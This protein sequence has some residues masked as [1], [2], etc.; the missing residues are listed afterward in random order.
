MPSQRLCCRFVAGRLIMFVCVCVRAGVDPHVIVTV[1][2]LGDATP[3][4]ICGE[5]YEG[6]R[7]GQCAQNYF[8]LDERCFFCQT[9]WNSSER[10][11]DCTARA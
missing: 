3:T 6:P 9:T 11:S 2:N 8:Q 5:G 7:C 10:E 4:Q 1:V